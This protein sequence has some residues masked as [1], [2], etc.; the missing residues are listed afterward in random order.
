MTFQATVFASGQDR[1]GCCR[2]HVGSE[3]MADA[4]GWV[5]MGSQRIAVVVKICPA[6]VEALPVP[7]DSDSA[8]AAAPA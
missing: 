4:M 3:E 7:L 1:C 6:C 2:R 8:L 5:N